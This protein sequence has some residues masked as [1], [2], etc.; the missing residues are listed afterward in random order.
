MISKPGNEFLFKNNLRRFYLSV[1]D[2]I[3]NG[4]K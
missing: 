1:G 4:S 2:V 3:E